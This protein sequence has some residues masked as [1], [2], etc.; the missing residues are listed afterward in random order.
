MVHIKRRRREVRIK[1]IMPPTTT[2]FLLSILLLILLSTNNLVNAQS[3][4]YFCGI[5]WSDAAETCPHSCPSGEDSECI[6]KAGDDTYGCFFFTGCWERIQAGEITQP[7]VPVPTNS[8]IVGGMPTQEPTSDFIYPTMVP[9]FGYTLGIQDVQAELIF[10]LDGVTNTM[11]VDDMAVFLDTITTSLGVELEKEGVTINN[12]G[13]EDPGIE[14]I[15]QML[16]FSFD[17]V[18]ITLSI[19]AT[20]QPKPNSNNS[21]S[22]GGS[23]YKIA[24]EYIGNKNGGKTIIAKLKM[25]GLQTDSS[26][27]DKASSLTVSGGSSSVVGGETVQPSGSP[28]SSPTDMVRDI[29]CCCCCC[30]CC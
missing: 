5:S 7:P 18:D 2:N 22:N 29:C 10:T 25:A 21:G 26:Y 23:I 1:M 24:K 3:E 9:T 6:E 27:F 30:C 17:Y 4:D 14:I 13:E 16:G 19:S 12:N 15:S 8:P 20:Y 11:Q 28:L